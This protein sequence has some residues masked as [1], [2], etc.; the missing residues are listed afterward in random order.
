M[1]IV[2]ERTAE[3][4]VRFS[5]YHWRNSP[6]MRRVYRLGFV[7]A[8]VSGAV[9]AFLL[10]KTSPI[11]ATIA[12]VST[13]AM[14]AAAYVWYSS[15]WLRRSVRMLLAEGHNKGQL[16]QHE[17]EI[18]ADAV[19][20]RTAH[21]QSRHSWTVIER[22]AEDD[23]YIFIYTQP[24]AAHVIPK[25]AFESPEQAATF[26]DAAASFHRAAAAGNPAQ[27]R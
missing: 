14:Y 7:G 11:L 16:G 22:V 25:A 8:P 27:P 18:S 5:E 4:L 21:D 2:F 10:A 6:A 15:W 9:S 3:D 26:M 20:E 1:K 19:A 24:T 12:F 13:A 23:S 17:I